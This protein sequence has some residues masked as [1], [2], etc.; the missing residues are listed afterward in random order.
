M[1][2]LYRLTPTLRLTA[3]LLAGPAEAAPRIIDEACAQNGCFA[4][5]PPGLPVIIDEPGSYRLG[6]N[7]EMTRRDP[8]AIVVTAPN[9]HIDMDGFAILGENRCEWTGETAECSEPNRGH[10]IFVL[11]GAESVSIVNGSISGIAGTGIAVRAVGA[12]IE[13]VIVRDVTFD[14][15]SIGFGGG[16]VVDCMVDRAGRIGF[17][18]PNIGEATLFSRAV[19]SRSTAA[20]NAGAMD[21]VAARNNGQ[22]ISPLSTVIDGVLDGYNVVTP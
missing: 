9:V 8:Y 12:R 11:D 2:L 18:A 13:D 16:L 15:I 22:D 3:G 19:V 17:F 7:L 5:D 1:K 21:N 20:F 14:G 6:S 4:G 10:A